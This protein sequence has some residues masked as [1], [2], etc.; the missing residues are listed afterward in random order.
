MCTDL[1][2]QNYV[3]HR[4]KLDILLVASVMTIIYTVIFGYQIDYHPS[5]NI[6][7]SISE[8]FS[9][10]EF[11]ILAFGKPG[12]YYLKEHLIL[13][14]LAIFLFF[15]IFFSN[16]FFIEVSALKTWLAEKGEKIIL[17]F[18]LGGLHKLLWQV[19]V[20]FWS[21]TPCVDIFSL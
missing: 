2:E 11:C 7:S 18:K 17:Y 6:Q 14:K 1:Y 13:L 16:S 12:Q 19:F 21:P 20:L 3:I 8:S 4:E 15:M 10:A 9:G 5:R